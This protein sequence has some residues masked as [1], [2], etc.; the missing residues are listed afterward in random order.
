MAAEDEPTDNDKMKKSELRQIIREEIQKV[1]DRKFCDYCMEWVD[2]DVCPKC[3]NE[4]L[5]DSATEIDEDR[6]RDIAK[7]QYR[8]TKDLSQYENTAAKFFVDNIQEM[9]KIA[10][11][12]EKLVNFI[13]TG[14]AEKS[15]SD[16]Y[17]K[18]VT[19]N[20]NKQ[21][22]TDQLMI[23]ITNIM[24]KGKGLGVGKSLR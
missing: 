11:D 2:G 18:K 3:G 13:T 23:Y 1:E 9:W 21:R 24:L 8:D 20:I 12:R 6:K 5:C 10:S 19:N 7:Q 22:T 15:V 17:L 4:D 16:E 14:L